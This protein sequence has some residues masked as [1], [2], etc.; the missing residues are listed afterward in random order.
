MYLLLIDLS[1]LWLSCKLA[2][3]VTFILLVISIP[4]AYWL[5]Y[6]KFKLKTIAEVIIT[7]PLV[8]PPSVLGFYLLIAFSPANAFGKFIDIYFNLRLVFT[9]AGLIVASVIYSL[10]FMVNPVVAGFKNLPSSLKEASFTLG[11]SKFATVTK[12]LLPNIR[13]SLLTG[14]VMTFAHTI[15]EFGVV[16][17][18]GGSIPKETRVVSIAVYDEVES[19]NYH[20]ANVYALILFVFTFLILLSV[21]LINNKNR[22]TTLL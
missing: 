3:I 6:S 22:A 17:M 13:M 7:L 15:G 10:P 14:I 12:I 9:F 4:L 21:H 18:V 2:L 1:P 8:L 16:L 19:M 11:K 20:N 5:A